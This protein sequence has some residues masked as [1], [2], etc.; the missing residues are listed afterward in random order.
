LNFSIS[1]GKRLQAALTQKMILCWS[2]SEVGSFHAHVHPFV[3]GTLTTHKTKWRGHW[4]LKK[5]SAKKAKL[6]KFLFVY[7]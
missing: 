4:R 7:F 2:A 6:L 1:I 5:W 3:L